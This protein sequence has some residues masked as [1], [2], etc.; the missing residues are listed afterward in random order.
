MCIHLL[1]LKFYSNKCFLK[2]CALLGST[3]KDWMGW[4]LCFHWIIWKFKSS[5]K[6]FNL[7][8][9]L[10]YGPTESKKDCMNKGLSKNSFWKWL[11]STFLECL[12]YWKVAK[13]VLIIWQGKELHSYLVVQ[14]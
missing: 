7:G 13:V 6:L 5:L 1:W 8:P 4:I 12:I 3:I 11:H 2:K 10:I 9:I 14:V